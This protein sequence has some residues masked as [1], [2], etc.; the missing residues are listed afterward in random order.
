M[1]VDRFTVTEEH[2]KL[3][4]QAYVRWE[5]CEFGA[6]AIDCK[7]PY[8][9]SSVYQSIGEILAIPFDHEDGDYWTDATLAQM[10]ITHQGTKTALQIFLATGVME[11][12][13][14]ETPK[15]EQ[16][17]RKVVPAAS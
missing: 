11:A 6:P 9:D 5:S 2:I 17:W 13:E 14:Y 3:L 10:S 15:Y 7:R 4:R 16:T 1:S 12:G 8:G